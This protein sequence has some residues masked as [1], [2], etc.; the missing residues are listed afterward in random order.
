[1][2][3]VTSIAEEVKPEEDLKLLM[4]LQF[5][6]TFALGYSANALIN[7]VNSLQITAH[8]PLNN[9]FIYIQSFEMNKQ[10]FA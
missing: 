6:L 9:V 4:I 7:M 1:M 3:K 2:P 10:F 8:L 5:I